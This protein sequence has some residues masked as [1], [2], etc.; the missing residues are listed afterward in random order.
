MFEV[1]S[2]V[3]GD[4]HQFY[5]QDDD[6]KITGN[7]WTDEALEERVCFGQGFIGV[8]TLTSR[9]IKV[10]LKVKSPND[11]LDLAEFELVKSVK[12]IF[13]SSHMYMAGCV[14]DPKPGS[15]LGVVPGE[16]KI[17]ICFGGQSSIESEFD[18]GE[19]Y[20]IYVESNG[21]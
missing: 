18:E 21:T 9:E 20:V 5:I 14:E 7:E 12:T 3:S 2:F 1:S 4:Y 13:N 19:Y 17:T 10:T 15:S 16:Y 8:S 11:V 6:P